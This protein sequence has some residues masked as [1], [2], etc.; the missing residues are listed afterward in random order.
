MME[1]LT[2][3]KEDNY[4][5]NASVSHTNE[6]NSKIEKKVYTINIPKK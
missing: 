1:E 2:E 5:L 3:V 4:K 6:L